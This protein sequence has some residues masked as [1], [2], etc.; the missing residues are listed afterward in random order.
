[1]GFS[2]LLGLPFTPSSMGLLSVPL[3]SLCLLAVCSALPPS[4]VF[5]AEAPTR[6]VA[7]LRSWSAADLA[8]FDA[9]W[10]HLKFREGSAVALEFDPGAPWFDGPAVDLA[11]IESIL[12]RFPVVQVRRTFSWD[13]AMTRGWKHAGEQRSGH[14]GP[15]LSLWFDV[16]TQGGPSTLA[17]LLDALNDAPIVEIAHPAPIVEN[18]VSYP[19]GLPARPANLIDRSAQFSDS[20]ARLADQ[21]ALPTPDF[22]GQQGYL[23]APPNGLDAPAAWATPGGFGTGRRFIDVELGWTLD[24]EDFDTSHQFYNGGAPWTANNHGTAVLG[25]VIGRHNGMGVN[26]FAPDVEHGVVSITEEEWPNV[27]HYFQETIDQL[28]AGDVWLIELQMYPPGRGATP[29]EWL[30]VNYDVIWTSSWALDITCIEAGA[31]GGQDLDLPSWNGVFD[32]EVRDSGAILVAAGTPTGLVAESFSNYGS[33]FD[34]HAWGSSIVTTGYGN[35]YNGG[36]P[37]TQYTNSFSGTSGASPMAAGA[38]LCLQGI[39]LAANGGYVDPI[40]LRS[41]LHD[42]GTPHLDPVREIG[43]RPDLEAAV[44]ELLSSASVPAPETSPLAIRLEPNPLVSDA[45]VRFELPSAGAF[46]IS[47]YDLSGRQRWSHADVG[48]AGLQQIPLNR[49]ELRGAVGASGSY[50]LEL[51]TGSHRESIRLLLR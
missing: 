50:F 45:Y 33:R 1:M 13:P 32:R 34:V 21:P 8:T 39:A 14:P 22:S 47:L 17:L 26:G 10:L 44:A 36:N 28:S 12:D 38:A 37:R 25:E 20:P 24:H 46:R 16:Q 19:T 11:E 43:P 9:S 41:I 2:S 51:D 42:T 35:L 31:N 18:A 6:I 5:A 4:D 27:P 49:T 7:P 48:S 30:Q 40:L 3:S 15:D 29:M 23:Y